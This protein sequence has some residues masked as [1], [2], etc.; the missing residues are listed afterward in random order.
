MPDLSAI[1]AH[2][3]Q[4]LNDNQVML[5]ALI[6]D[7][8]KEKSSPATV[9]RKQFDVVIKQARVKDVTENMLLDV[10]VDRECTLDCDIYKKH[11]ISRQLFHKRK[12]MF[13][14]N[15]DLANKVYGSSNDV[16]ETPTMLQFLFLQN[17]TRSSNA[18][19]VWALIDVFYYQFTPEH[20][21]QY[22]DIN[23]RLLT[24]KMNSIISLHRQ[25]A[26]A[27]QSQHNGGHHAG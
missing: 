6:S 10:F 2:K 20:A 1:A 7:A 27:F 26:L 17:Q 24:R 3:W 5:N 15:W 21:A 14:R 22:H 4:K 25:F 18:A 19:F 16:A 9:T 23:L 11:G 8:M 12:T 13:L